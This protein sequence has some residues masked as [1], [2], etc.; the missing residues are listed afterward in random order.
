MKLISCIACCFAL[1][2]PAAMA[3]TPAA[4]AASLT[5]E[6]IVEKNAAAR[7]GLDAW[8][9]VT[10]MAFSG[11][12]DAGGKNDAKLPFTMT[13][14]R[15]H[16]SRLEL[17]FREQTALQIYDGNQ[18]WKVRPFL[19]RNEV[20]PFTPTEAKSAAGWTQLDGPLIDHAAKGTQ[21]ELT[22]AEN[23]EGKSTYRLKVTPKSGPQR[24][25]WVDAKSFLEVR[26]EGEPR[27]IDGKMRP[28][29]VY[30]RDYKSEKGLAIPRVLES[31]VEGV[32]GSHKMT[33]QS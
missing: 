16:K 8:R 21:V 15:P 5:A 7:G 1:A 18:G 6:Q 13:L 10:T 25:I 30:Y 28:V 14:K 22:G 27:R 9:A 3:A 26:I 4:P 2:S 19:N 23:V 11:E 33:I 29:F 24:S 20:E 31:V 12:M 32:K 17:R